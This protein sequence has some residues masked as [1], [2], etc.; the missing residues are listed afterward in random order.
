MKDAN[1]NMEAVVDAENNEISIQ[2][3]TKATSEYDGWST[4][5]LLTRN[6]KGWGAKIA[7]LWRQGVVV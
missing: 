3:D 7:A 2:W 4:E 1:C 6:G 5:A